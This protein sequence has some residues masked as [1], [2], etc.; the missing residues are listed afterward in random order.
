MI[1]LVLCPLAFRMVRIDFISPAITN[2]NAVDTNIVYDTFTYIKMVIL[3]AATV[4]LLCCFLYKLFA[5]DYQLRFT[6]YD[7]LIFALCMT[8][9]ISFFFSEQKGIALSGFIYMLDGTLTHVCFCMLFLFGFH[10]LSEKDLYGRFVIPVCIT[11]SINAVIS[12]L[13]FIGIKMIDTAVIKAILGIPTGARATSAA[14]FTSTFGNINYLSGFGGICFALFFSRLILSQSK[15]EFWVSLAMTAASFSIVI[16]ALSS[17]GFFTFVVMTPIILILTLFAGLTKR[18]L[19]AAG[20]G[21]AV[22]VLIFIPLSAMNPVVIDE[23]FGLFGF[24]QS[25]VLQGEPFLQ[26]NTSSQNEPYLNDALGSPK[27][28]DA[29]SQVAGL[30]QLSASSSESMTV[31]ELTA[32]GAP[33]VEM[34][35]ST[36]EPIELPVF[37]EAAIA[38]GTGRLYIW[39]ETIKL[40]MKR[41]L[42][43]Y[44]MD[45]ITYNYPQMDT[46]KISGLGNYRIFVTKPHN[47]FLGYAYGAGIPALLIFLLLNIF[48]AI[49]FA[50]YIIS[51]RKEEKTV[52]CFIL[53]YGIT[54]IAYIV[55]ALVNDDLIATAP[56]WWTLF[57]IMLGSLRRETQ[58]VLGK[59]KI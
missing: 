35:S 11:C 6:K 36:H 12:L 5:T 43:G 51:C 2:T 50:S 19:A 15:K 52:D 16:T 31:T 24:A 57:G 42:I 33:S 55:Q 17:S 3:Y 59:P 34:T 1:L 53:L 9:F 58:M 28:V 41:P 4:V 29:A 13:N 14:A 37:P 49:Q 21:L 40:I 23:T 54:W 26:D 45:T 39:R 48:A 10:V 47:V 27:Q 22:C 8:L 32:H 44:G 30:L 38:P 20:V 56:I 25:N 7:W 18:K 46:A